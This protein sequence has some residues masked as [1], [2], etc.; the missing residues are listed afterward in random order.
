MTGL[1]FDW[2]DRAPNDPLVTRALAELARRFGPSHVH[3]RI[4]SSGTGLHVMIGTYRFDRRTRSVCLA[5][6]PMLPAQQF[7]LRAEFGTDPWVDDD[8][9]LECPGRFIS[10]STRAAAGMTTSRIFG[11]K[12]DTDGNPATCGPWV[13]WGDS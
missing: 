11:V 8:G 5:P 10:D 7:A 12:T 2:D 9:P 1:T 3:Y 4:S 6:A 13:C